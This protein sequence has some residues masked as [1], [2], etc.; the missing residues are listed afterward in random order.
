MTDEPE[1]KKLKTTEDGPTGWENHTMN[2]SE[3]LVKEVEGQQFQEL[4]NAEVS[5]LK[6]I[7]PFSTGVL[8]ALGIRTICELAKY[9][10][11]LIARAIQTLSATE[12]KGGRLKGSRINVDNAVDK[13]YETKTLKEM[14]EAPVEA[15]DGIGSQACELL[16]TLGV[17]TVSDLAEFKYCR[18]AEAIV[19]AAEFGETKTAKER[20]VQAA[21]KKLE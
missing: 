3:A 2:V 14:C 10:F 18:W 9:K 7:G 6:G 4:V 12:T 8:D 15:L 21:L 1:A 16:E 13:E 5:A 11:F 19:H 20:K 17:R